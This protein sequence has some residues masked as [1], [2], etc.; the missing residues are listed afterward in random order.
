MAIYTDSL[1]YLYTMNN[2]SASD[3]KNSRSVYKYILYV[4]IFILVTIFLVAGSVF[5]VLGIYALFL[6]CKKNA[7]QTILPKIL[8]NK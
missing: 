1:I 2:R 6:Y 3:S 7:V 5:Y 8:F 4:V